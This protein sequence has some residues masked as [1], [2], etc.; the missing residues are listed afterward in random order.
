VVQRV[1]VRSAVVL[2]MAVVSGAAE[3][4]AMKQTETEMQVRVEVEPQES[5]GLREI[6][7]MEIELLETVVGKTVYRGGA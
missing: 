7:L 3:T 6:E 4:M 5:I 1:V 2:N